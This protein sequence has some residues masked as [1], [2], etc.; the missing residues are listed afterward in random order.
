ILELSTYRLPMALPHPNPSGFMMSTMSAQTV[1]SEHWKTDEERKQ[2]ADFIKTFRPEWKLP[3]GKF[4]EWHVLGLD[5][6]A[7]P[8]AFYYDKPLVILQD[9]SSF[10]ASDIFL[11]AFED[12]P[13]TTQMGAPSGGGNG[14]M[15][16]YQLPN[17][18]LGFIL[19]QSAKFRPNGKLYDGRGIAPDILMEATPEDLLGKSDTVLDAAVKRLKEG[20]AKT[21]SGQ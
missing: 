5:A 9:S 12:H 10:S 8:A 6:K 20:A 2:V 15:E 19:C 17:T 18:G 4:S 21:A 3:E 14:W 11:G 13:N 7:N 1:G 16:P